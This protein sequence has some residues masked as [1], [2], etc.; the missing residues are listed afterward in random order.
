M[1]ICTNE[2]VESSPDSRERYNEE[3]ITKSYLRSLRAIP[4][5]SPEQEFDLGVRSMT[6]DDQTSR[7]KLVIHNIAFVVSI[8]I[9]YQKRGL[10]MI[11]L[12]QEGTKSLIRSTKKFDP[13]EGNRLITYA[14]AGIEGAM[15]RAIVEQ[16][17]IIS[18]PSGLRVRGVLQTRFKFARQIRELWSRFGREPTRKEIVDHTGFVGG[19]ELAGALAYR[20][21]T[22]SLSA[23]VDR[24]LR[25][26]QEFGYVLADEKAV[27]PSF[28]IDAKELIEKERIY[29]NNL[30]TVLE[31]L[32]C[33]PRNR[34]IFLHCYGL[35]GYRKMMY[36]D[37]ALMFSIKKQRIDQILNR[38][39]EL[40]WVKN[41]KFNKKD[42]EKSLSLI[43]DLEEVV[44]C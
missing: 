23:E 5:L 20:T 9:K 3:G 43:A 4:Q 18:K 11:D 30:A 14:K 16:S 22:V 44:L 31:T 27:H 35:G 38:I 34:I 25:D 24:T 39:W 29:L 2:E 37:V 10:S 33:S 17:D 19:P 13:Y 12:I 28:I 8:A 15:I 6:G 21:R 7:D 40:F 41:P 32:S 42:L 26:S 1:N 36:K